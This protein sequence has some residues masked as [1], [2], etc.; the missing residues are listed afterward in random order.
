LQAS[1]GSRSERASSG[2]SCHGRV[3]L[4]SKWA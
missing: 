3:S 1:K 2:K 4:A